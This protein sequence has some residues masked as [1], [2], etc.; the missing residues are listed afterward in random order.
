MFRPRLHLLLLACQLVLIGAA[1]LAAEAPL[2]AVT[3][4]NRPD[5]LYVPVDEAAR[6]LHWRPVVDET[7]RCVQLGALPL[8]PGM[9]RSL[10]DGRELIQVRDLELAGA[11]VSAADSPAVVTVRR[12]FYGFALTSSAK[13]VEI[14]LPEQQLRAWQGSRLVLQTHISSGRNGRT[15]AGIFQAGPF[16]ARMHR[17]S[18]Y[19]NA[20]MPWS[21]QIYGNVFI[22][23]FT[24]VPDYPASHGCIRVP[25]DGGNPA[26]FFY[27]WVDDG[28]PVV[29]TAK[30]GQD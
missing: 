5:I 1:P 21:V 6:E 12:G 3:F 7:G 27:E 14:S 17:S 11:T 29:V 18:L 4:A 25:L 20:P 24:E 22:H 13:R 30:R 2:E 10:V 23:G 9:L 15:P 19:H 8:A 16:R 26:R 28:A